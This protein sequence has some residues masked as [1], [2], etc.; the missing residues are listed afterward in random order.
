MSALCISRSLGSQ[1]LKEKYGLGLHMKV[2]S[3]LCKEK[4]FSSKPNSNLT[5]SNFDSLPFE[6][7]FQAFNKL[8]IHITSQKFKL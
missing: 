7:S 5:T 2:A 1:T 8:L 4:R 6:K 3:S